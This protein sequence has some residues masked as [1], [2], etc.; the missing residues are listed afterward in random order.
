LL[1][2]ASVK[3]TLPASFLLLSFDN[4]WN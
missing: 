2:F 3:S 1:A 4:K